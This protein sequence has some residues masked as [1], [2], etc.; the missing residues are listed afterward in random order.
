M[1]APRRSSSPL[2]LMLLMMLSLGIG[3]G[4]FVGQQ[5]KPAATAR[6]AYEA[7]QELLGIASRGNKY[8]QAYFRVLIGE[9]ANVNGR[10]SDGDT[11]LMKA[12]SAA[13]S[14]EWVTLLIEAGADVNAKN[15]YGHTPLMN[16][17]AKIRKGWEA[18]PKMLEVIKLLKAAGARE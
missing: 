12:A 18:T 17:G 1:D 9:G 2:M 8:S 16:S 11:P 10:N 3:V 6:V 15:E 4:Y 13:S 7:T 14:P 5:Q